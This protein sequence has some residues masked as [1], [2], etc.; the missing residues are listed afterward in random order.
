MTSIFTLSPRRV[1]RTITKFVTGRGFLPADI[2]EIRRVYTDGR[3]AWSTW[4]RADQLTDE[5]ERL[6]ADNA[7][8]ANVYIGLNPRRAFGL[9]KDDAVLC[10]RGLFA[11][12][13]HATIEAVA[14]ALVTAGMPP[15]SVVVHSGHGLHC[16]W[17]LS[18]EIE[19]EGWKTWQRDLAALVGSDTTVHNPER[20]ARLPGL[21]N[22][23]SEPVPCRLIECD[24]SRVFDLC[25]LP[26]PLRAGSDTPVPVF[27]FRRLR[28][29]DDVGDPVNRC[30][31]YLAKLPHAVAGAGGHRT[32][33]YV[34]NV[35][36]RFGVPRDDA[37]ELMREYSIRCDPPWSERE[38]E[39]KVSD[40]Y[41]R[42]PGQHGAKLRE[43]SNIA[44]VQYLDCRGAAASN[45]RRLNPVFTFRQ[46]T[47]EVA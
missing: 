9:R 38:I 47:R 8:G 46:R 42:N 18:A 33:W 22:L 36:N 15:P 19:A 13:D 27:R 40:A 24:P 41:H 34:A 29:A 44:R 3:P 35:C 26:I 16:Y 43:E 21:L 10:A 31:R 4:H 17:N 7:D 39:H 12:F 37:L 45:R 30:R 20:I 5:A 6:L 1:A 11:D 14:A 28:A 2:I 23:K 32:T 25:D